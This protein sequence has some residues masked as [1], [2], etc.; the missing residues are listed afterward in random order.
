MSRNYVAIDPVATILHGHAL[1]I[2]YLIHHPNEP[3]L[4]AI[5]EALRKASPEDRA[6]IATRAKVMIEYAQAIE[7]IAGKVATK[8]AGSQ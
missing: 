6:E 1:D 7:N 5:E 3:A 8:S 4:K 2:Y